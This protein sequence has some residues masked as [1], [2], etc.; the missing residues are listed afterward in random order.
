M[1]SVLYYI[2]YSVC[3]LISLLPFKI[4]YFLSDLLYFPLYYWIRYRRRIVRKNLITSFPDKTKKEIIVIE[5]KF[6]AFFCDYIVET[7]KL[8][9]IRKA[10]MYKRMTFKNIEDCDTYIRQGRSCGVY[11]GHYCNW[12]W[13]TSFPM[14]THEQAICGQVYHILQNKAFERL[15]LRLRERYG[16]ISIPMGDTLRK[17]ITFRNENRPFIIGFISDQAPLWNSIHYWT[18]FLNHDTPVFTGTERIAKQTNLVVY[19]ADITRPKRGYYVCE[20]R[21]LTDS[22]ADFSDYEITEMY[23][24]ELEKTIIKEPQYWLWTHNRWK[25]TREEFNER[26]EK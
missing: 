6:Y 25:R 9:S 11:L 8:L 5:K 19:Y 16:A 24:R 18:N 23:M 20:F 22:P 10:N 1:W 17:I 14:Y 21:K 26:Y 2:L 3:F 7:I 4:L 13:I 12:E 15:F